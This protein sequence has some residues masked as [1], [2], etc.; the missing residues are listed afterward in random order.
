MSAC[1]AQVGLAEL[2][3]DAEIEWDAASGFASPRERRS[4]LVNVFLGKFEEVLSDL[5]SA[6]HDKPPRFAM[7]ATECKT[8]CILAARKNGR[9]KEHPAGT[10]PEAREADELLR[11]TCK[12]IMDVTEAEPEFTFCFENPLSSYLKNQVLPSSERTLPYPAL[13]CLS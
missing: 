12:W 4:E 11:Q 8:F 2:G 13:L 5:H 6:L 9:T 7:I 3:G 10:S 1:F